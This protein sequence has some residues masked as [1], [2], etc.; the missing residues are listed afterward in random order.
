MDVVTERPRPATNRF[1]PWPAGP[2]LS[3]PRVPLGPGSTEV[4]RSP[5]WRPA[6]CLAR[7]RF[8]AVGDDAISPDTSSERQGSSRAS[9]V[10]VRVPWTLAL[11]AEA[12]RTNREWVG[13]CDD[14][15]PPPEAVPP[16]ADHLAEPLPRA[17]PRPAGPAGPDDPAVCP[18]AGRAVPLGSLCWE[19]N[20]G[21]TSSIDSQTISA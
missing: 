10:S 6:D 20:L 16:T 14:A 18:A 13:K 21:Y 15:G 4:S 9:G 1:P 11:P 17:A 19:R 8:P 12:E 2:E 5:T 7:K 3:S